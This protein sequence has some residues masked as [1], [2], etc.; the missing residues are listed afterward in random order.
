MLVQSDDTA[1]C[2]RVKR[3]QDVDVHASNLAAWDQHYEQ[4]S[5][6]AFSGEVRELLDGELQLFEEV[7]SCATSQRCQP[8]QGGLWVG[9]AVPDHGA[10]LRFMGRPVQAHELMVA[11]S[12]TP[13]DLQVPAGH[14]LYGMVLGQAALERH[15]QA[16]HQQAWPAGWAPVPS[17]Q[18][19][20]PLQRYRLQ[21]MLREVLR[22]LQEQPA[23]LHHGA[24]RRSLREALMTVL[25]DVLLPPSLSEAVTPRQL[26]RHE[27]VH[28]VR[29]R[30]FEHPDAPLSVADLC[31][32]LHVT[33]RTLQNCFQDV[34]G[35]SPATYLRTV[36]LNAVRRALREEAPHASTIADT[37][38]R[39]GFWH[40]GH[41][42]QDYKALFGETP[43]QTRL[44][45]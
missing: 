18:T 16:L 37:A 35:M 38:A 45:A 15:L 32:H 21:G 7:A 20:S 24:S 10:G 33:R 29:E 23:A 13:F 43:S 42:S 9:L 44:H 17:V 12:E 1:V 5:C 11:R 2:F 34:L 25:C 27:L 36:R 19:L 4:T 26:R 3:T 39:W 31:T 30:V 41:F 8:W 22:C 6:G 40:M 14:G 28:R